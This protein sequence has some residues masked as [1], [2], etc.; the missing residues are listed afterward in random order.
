MI[1]RWLG[2]GTIGDTKIGVNY[3]E[4]NLSQAQGEVDPTLV[5]RNSKV[6]VGLYHHLTKNLTLLGEMTAIEA[7]NQAGFTNDSKTFNVGTFL[8][9]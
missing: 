4:S 5:R 9:F 6:T 1:G 7:E 2:G 8:E 3:G